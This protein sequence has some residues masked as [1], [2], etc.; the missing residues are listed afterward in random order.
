MEMVAGSFVRNDGGA[1]MRGTGEW[2]LVEV[3]MLSVM[4]GNGTGGFVEERMVV[5]L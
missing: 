1:V 2:C 5:L 4:R 3:V